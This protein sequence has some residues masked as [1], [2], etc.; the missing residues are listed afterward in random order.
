[1]RLHSK[2]ADRSLV[3]SLDDK[4]LMAK[5]NFGIIFNLSN[6]QEDN[7]TPETNSIAASI[8]KDK[9]PFDGDIYILPHGDIIAVCNSN[10]N[11][12]VDDAIFQMKYLFS[13]DPLTH[14]RN[15]ESFCNQFNLSIDLDTFY[16]QCMYKAANSN[17]PSQFQTPAQAAA[18]TPEEEQQ[19]SLLMNLT[20][21]V[22]ELVEELDFTKISQNIPVYI[23]KGDINKVIFEEFKIDDKALKNELCMKTDLCD[24]TN[25]FYFIREFVEIHLLISLVN[26]IQENK[27][28]IG[29]CIELNINTI[30]SEEFK[31]FD[32]ALN[33]SIRKSIIIGIHIGDVYRDINNYHK[34]RNKLA[35]KG[36]KLCITGVDHKSFLFVD[37]KILEADLIKLQ[38]SSEMNQIESELSNE[39]IS[40][41]NV[42]G[43][44][45]VILVGI[46]GHDISQTAQDIGLSLYQNNGVMPSV[47]SPFENLFQD[48][49]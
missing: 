33:E 46:E 23:K 17:I 8:L 12:L 32:S 25:I 45:R 16:A 7:K 27:R 18:N 4:K 5:M 3:S 35:K 47:N 39:L 42:T 10:D 49:A 2:R 31:I 15:K 11:E 41:I 44:S 1:M 22:E 14:N 26:I 43:S 21:K 36:Y 37:R 24:N 40:K 9:L 38:W 34:V 20:H 6:L 13:D 48:V 28:D 19:D 30:L 29:Y